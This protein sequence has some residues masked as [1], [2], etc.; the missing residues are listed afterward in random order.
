MFKF[1][2][3]WRGF[4]RI[5]IIFKELLRCQDHSGSHVARKKRVNLEGHSLCCVV[6]FWTTNHD[7]FSPTNCEEKSPSVHDLNRL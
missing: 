2:R 1:T 3:V 4:E 6:L 5:S 7:Q